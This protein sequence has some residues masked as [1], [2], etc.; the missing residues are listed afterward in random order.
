MKELLKYY[1]HA[2]YC[3][4]FAGCHRGAESFGHDVDEAIVKL[5]CKQCRQKAV[6]VVFLP[7][8]HLGKQ[9]FVVMLLALR[10]I[11]TS[12]GFFFGCTVPMV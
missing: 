2:L 10:E 1:I 4:R 5:T 11:H 3:S 8:T 9:L 12:L 6:G 7:C